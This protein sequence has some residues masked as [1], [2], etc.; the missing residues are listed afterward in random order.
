MLIDQAKI[1]VK[2]GDGGDGCTSFYRDRLVRKGPP[3]GGDGGDGG[4]IIFRVDENTRTL[5]DFQYKRHFKAS[6]GSHGSSNNK[7]GKSGKDLYI[8]LPPG[9]IIKDAATDLILRDLRNVGEE[10]RV[11]VGGRCGKGNSKKRLGTSGEK[12]EEKKL[13]LELKLIA[14]VGIIAYIESKIEN[15]KLPLHD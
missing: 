12:G 3:N 5:L 1:Y 4:D 8:R 15:R 10:V 7:K 6:G 13:G 9:T 11:A 14:D 2:A